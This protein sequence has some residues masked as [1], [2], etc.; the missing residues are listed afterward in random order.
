MNGAHDMGGMQNFGPV[1]PEIDEPVFHHA[2][3]CRVFGLTIAMGA[4]GAW[5]LDQSRFARESV[6]P[7]QYLASS[8]YQIWL[9]GMQALMLERGLVTAEELADGR[10]HEPPR[11]LPL[12]LTADQVIPALARGAQ[13]VRPLAGAP[14]FRVGDPVRARDLHP[15][16]HTRLPRYCRGKPG[17]IAAVHGAHLF[18]DAHARGIDEPLEWLYT[19]RF[20]A[21]ALWGADTTAASVC[22]DCW[23]SYLD[24][25]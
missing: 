14:R 15:A 8:Y 22:V 11:P 5:N 19:V 24:A 7:A 18:A 10:L 3:E 25:G 12:L 1:V 17:T 9:A 13:P 4:T 21:H 16:T 6:P 2:W 23:E 20:D